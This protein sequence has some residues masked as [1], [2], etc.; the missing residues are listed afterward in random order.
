LQGN[1]EPLVGFKSL[2]R[3]RRVNGERVIRLFLFPMAQNM[4]SYPMAK[5]ES[6]I[7]WDDGEEYRIKKVFRRNKGKQHYK[8]IV[9]FQ[10][11]VYDLIDSHQYSTMSRSLTFDA[12]L[13]FIFS[14]TGYTYNIVDSFYAQEWENFGDEHKLSLFQKALERYQA[15][16]EVNGTHFTFKQRIGKRGDFQFRYGYNIKTYNEE[17]DTTSLSTYI[18][19]TGAE[20]ISASYTS[21]NAEKFPSDS[22]PDGLRHA[23][24]VRDERYTTK[25]GLLE[26][27]KE[28]IIDTPDASITID[29]VDM[30]RAG[31]PYD[32][33]NEGDD[34][35][36]IYEPMDVDLEARIVEVD[37]EFNEKL[38]VI[39]T[40]VTLANFRNTKET[41]FQQIQKQVNSVV[42]RNGKVA[43]N[44]LPAAIQRATEA[45]QSAQ[46]ELEFNQGII[47]RDPDDPNRL[48]LFN[49]AGLG[50]SLDGGMTFEEAITYLGINTKLLTAGEINTNHIRIIGRDNKFYWDGEALWAIDPN[51]SNRYVR[52]NSEGLYI[53][54]GAMTIERPDGYK[55]MTD[56]YLNIDYRLQSH[57]PPY[58]QYGVTHEDYWLTT[59]STSYM[60][61]GYFNLKHDSRYLRLVIYTRV[62]NSE[63]NAA[64]R[65]IN[66]NDFSDIWAY[67]GTSSTAGAGGQ[68]VINIDLGVPDGRRKSFQIQLRSTVTDEKSYARILQMYMEG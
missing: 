44:V 34:V 58:I 67:G 63:N 15:E 39:K 12:C 27:L 62:D 3:N 51:D 41:A 42:D 20:G 7:E 19:G 22:T 5:E 47:A 52:F 26:R 28:E 14:G 16:F 61:F 45:L 13:D 59:K 38:E 66:A 1:A 6:V 37:E 46:T 48:V 21:P 2:G 11:V 53:A 64:I 9:A 29:F 57:Y 56:G 4:V 32:V 68:Q 23:K 24:P 40:K 18:E 65:V 60:N 30:R 50:I 49:S 43:Y 54:K 8:E 36:L 10:K 31:Y 55:V 35:F 17:V 25:S 33:P